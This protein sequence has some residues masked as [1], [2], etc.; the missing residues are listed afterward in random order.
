[1]FLCTGHALSRGVTQVRRMHATSGSLLRNMGAMQPPG[2][3][4]ASHTG[5]VRRAVHACTAQTPTSFFLSLFFSAVGFSQQG[6]LRFGLLS[7][8]RFF[9]NGVKKL[10]DVRP[11]PAHV[12]STRQGTRWPDAPRPFFT[13][14]RL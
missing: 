5:R 1:M 10:Q 6:A 9:G 8:N 12:A 14:C 3:E 4:G 11:A 2:P 7:F 13:Q